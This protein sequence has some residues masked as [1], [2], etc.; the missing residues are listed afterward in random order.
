MY[1]QDANTAIAEGRLVWLITLI[2]TAVFGKT[3]ATSSDV[4]DKMDGELIARCI[5]VMRFND[6]RLQLSNNTVPLKGNLRLEVSFIHMLEQ[7]RRAYIMD[8]ITR[9][10]AVYD[11]L[12]A[13]LRITEESD[14]LGVIVQK[15][16][17]NLKFWPSNSDLLDLSLSL[18][19]DLSL[20]YSAVRKLFRLPE[21]QLLLNNHTADHFMFLGP[22]IDYQTMKQRT[23]FYEALTRLLTTDYSDD[24]EM[25]QRFLRP[26]TG[27]FN[28]N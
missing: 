13:E 24:E 22:N 5:T 17:T 16:L 20:G 10:S 14:M 12:E 21:V 18:F 1:L 9:A 28:S 2:G 6:N 19:K 25:L 26:L 11:T 23:T 4:H 15:I 8:Q 7:F 27:R 3:T